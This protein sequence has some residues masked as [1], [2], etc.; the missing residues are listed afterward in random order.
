MKIEEVLERL[1]E[2]FKDWSLTPG[3]WVLMAHYAL[4]L[5]GYRVKLRKGHLNTMINK[6]RLP[7]KVSEGYETFPPKD[8]GWAEEFFSWMKTTN[9]DTDLVAYDPP[10]FRKSVKDT[11]LYQ[12]PNKKR[13]RLLTMEGGIKGLD[14]YLNFCTEEGVGE[15]KGRY[16]LERLE[17]MRK[18]AKEKGDKKAVLLANKILDKYKHLRREGDAKVPLKRVGQ[19]KGMSAFKGKVKGRVRVILGKGDEIGGVRT[20]EILVTKMTSVKAASIIPKIAA[21]ITDDGGRL[22]H[23]AILSREFKI[24]CIV[25]TKIATKALKTGDLVEV[26]AEKGIV[27]ILSASGG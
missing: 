16:L 7:W 9:F 11:V 27:R 18:A 22:C 20:G 2:L 12:L 15:E 3:D 23:A 14:Y 26:D 5:Q 10:V 24:P 13:I 25:G 21:I 19:F 17:D 6:D 4:K 1:E 8:S